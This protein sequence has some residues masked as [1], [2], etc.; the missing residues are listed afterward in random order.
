MDT[1]SNT[2]ETISLSSSLTGTFAAGDLNVIVGRLTPQN[3]VVDSTFLIT[4][5]PKFQLPKN[6]IMTVTFDSDFSVLYTET[7]DL[8]E[9]IAQGGLYTIS[10]CSVS[11]VVLTM[12][13]GATSNASVP[14]DFHYFGL[15][16]F[17]NANELLTG[18]SVTLTYKG[19]TIATASTFPS[20]T[21]GPTVSKYF[22]SIKN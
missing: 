20:I 17:P 18:F 22:F 13:M 8:I 2:I 7:I 1:S 19:A 15:L 5:D 3:P 12:T 4:V 11:G 16:R 14:I 21:T 9:C 10:D 6:S